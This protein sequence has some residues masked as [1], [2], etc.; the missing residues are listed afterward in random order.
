MRRILFSL[1][2]LLAFTLLG[3]PVASTAEPLPPNAVMVDIQRYLLLYSATGDE[4]FLARLDALGPI[5]EEGISGQRNA[6]S[7]RDMWG[8]YRGTVEKV[9]DAYTSRDVEL[10][11]AV[12]Q[13][14]E[15]SALFD[16]FILVDAGRKRPPS[17]T[18]N[19]RRLALLKALQAN[20]ELLGE[21]QDQAELDSLV[22]AIGKQF[23]DLPNGDRDASRQHGML[24]KRWQ[25]L[26]LTS[27]AGH[28]LLY[29]FNA[30]IEY[31]LAHL[32][33]D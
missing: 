27:N 15:V 16:A 24:Q 21:T 9:R 28:T 8:L 30:Q 11:S 31:L 2:S 29:P 22:G 6:A 4:R 13:A 5:F 33:A 23:D 10:K 1:C 32:P 12:S 26:L 3:Y 7:L 14:R 17:L 19:L 18:G 25:Y 20:R